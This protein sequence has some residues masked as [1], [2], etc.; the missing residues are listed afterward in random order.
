VLLEGDSLTKTLAL[1][2]LEHTQDWRIASII[3]ETLSMISPTSSWLVSHVNES[4]N[5]CVH[6]VANWATTIFHYGCIP[7]L[8]FLFGPSPTCFGKASSSFFLVP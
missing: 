4:V 2:K 5:F 6:H 3:S 7:T 1:Q 8:H